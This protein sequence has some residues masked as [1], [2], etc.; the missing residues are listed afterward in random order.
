MNLIKTS[1]RLIQ[2][3]GQYNLLKGQY[4]KAFEKKQSI[5]TKI[6]YI[7]QSKIFFQEVALELQNSLSVNASDFVTSAIQSVFEEKK[8]IFKLK[9]TPKRNKTEVEMFLRD[10]DEE[11]ALKDPNDIRNGGGI[12]DIIALALRIFLWSLK[13]NSNTMI[14]DQPCQNLDNGHMPMLG[15]LLKNLSKELG[16]QFILINHNPNLAE[17]AE[18]TYEVVK[19]GRVSSIRRV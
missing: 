3:K 16:I 11:V 8:Y 7:E 10:G 5:I 4:N 13:K 14:L 19:N 9:F 6:D 17:T 18:I 1:S 12:L 15:D 2:K